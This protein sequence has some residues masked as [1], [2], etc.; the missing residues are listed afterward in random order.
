M[1]PSSPHTKARTPPITPHDTFPCQIA[2]RFNAK[3]HPKRQPFDV[4]SARLQLRKHRDISWNSVALALR[5]WPYEAVFKLPQH[6]TI[7]GNELVC[8]FRIWAPDDKG[9]TLNL[10]DRKYYRVQKGT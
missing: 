5:R 7:W 3:V 2:R 10:D 8:T 4:A 1:P 6:T 9:G